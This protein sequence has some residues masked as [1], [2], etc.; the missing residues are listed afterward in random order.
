L[1]ILL[2]MLLSWAGFVIHNVADLPGQTLLS[3]ET[4][5]PT[6]VFAVLSV[7][8]LLKPSKLTAALL[9]FWAGLNFLGGGIISVLPLGMLP[10]DPEQTLY[11]YAFHVLY[12]VTQLPA[13]IL[14]ARFLRQPQQ[15]P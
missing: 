11:H 6:L 7:A 10:F 12:A 2:A 4:L 15:T 9:L 1:K 14:L 3:P 5:Y 8:W 13:L